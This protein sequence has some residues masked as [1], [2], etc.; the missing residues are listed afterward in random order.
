MEPILL[1]GPRSTGERRG[2][3]KR[4]SAGG[5]ERSQQELKTVF[6]NPA[7][8]GKHGARASFLDQ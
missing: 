8:K 4:E 3:L 5:A 1:T 2:T 6:T 7:F